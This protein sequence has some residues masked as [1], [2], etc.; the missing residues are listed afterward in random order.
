M[1]EF[2]V[3]VESTR[4]VEDILREEGV[5]NKNQGLENLHITLSNGK[6]INPKRSFKQNQL[7]NE[8]VIYVHL[9]LRGGS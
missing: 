1:K 6:T 2:T 3:Y 7:R 9:K 5:V 4:K 8:D